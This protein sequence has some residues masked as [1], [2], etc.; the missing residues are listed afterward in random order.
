MAACNNGASMPTPQD[1]AN[2]LSQPGASG[3]WHKPPEEEPRKAEPILVKKAHREILDHERKRRV[4]LKCVELQEMMEEK[5]YSEEDIR[6]KVSTFRQMLMEKEGVLTR[7]D[8]HGRQ[9]VIEDPRFAHGEECAMVCPPYGEGCAVECSCRIDCYRDYSGHRDYRMKR[10]LSSSCS[11]RP[12]KKKKKKSGHKRSRCDSSSPIRKDKKKKSGKKH[13]RDRSRSGSRKKRRHRSRSSKNK[14]K[15]RTKDRKRSRMESPSQRSHRH[16][17]CSSHSPSPSSDYSSGKSP[18]RYSP[19]H[20]ED[21]QHPSSHQSSRSPSSSHTCHSR[22]AT[23]H[24]NGHKTGTHNGRQGHGTLAEKSQAKLDSLSP[25]A[26]EMAKMESLSP[27]CR[28]GR[29]IKHNQE[30]AVTVS[31]G[32]IGSGA[33]GDR[34]TQH[35]RSRSVSPQKHRRWSKTKSDEKRES[36]ERSVSHTGYSSDSDGSVGSRAHSMATA[37][38]KKHSAP[39][40]KVKGRHHRGRPNSCSESAVKHSRHNS[41]RKKSVSRSPGHR[42]SSWS[43]SCSRSRSRDKRSVRSRSRSSSQKKNT[44]RDKENESRTRHTDST[45]ASR[46]RRRSRSYS[47]IRKRR[48]DSPSFMEA[49]RIT[50]ARKRPIPYYRPSPSSSSTLSSY[51]DS[52]SRSRSYDSYSSYSRSRSRSRSRSLSNNSRSSSESTGF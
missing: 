38:E 34:R 49:R 40:K 11:P 51:S 45:E 30:S 25:S 13:K 48:R 31:P 52:R 10:G 1:A 36:A 32:K 8:Q 26:R 19:K 22:S 4:E 42:G 12:R 20:R 29:G 27:G 47:P 28:D 35:H 21:G 15:D 14:R 23:P 2:G 6:Q 50:S 7:E 17:S 16:S 43:S 41:E 24:Q 39:N 5:G 37:T 46:P 44:S 33:P 18:G 9:I 3:S